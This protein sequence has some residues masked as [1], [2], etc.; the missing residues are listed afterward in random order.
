MDNYKEQEQARLQRDMEW[1]H[2]REMFNCEMHGKPC[3]YGI[4][5]EC[6]LTNP[7]YERSK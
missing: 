2:E 4:C 7:E 3:S 5:D 1:Q 6:P